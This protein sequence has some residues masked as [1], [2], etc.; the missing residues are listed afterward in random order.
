[1]DTTM[2]VFMYW[3]L[4]TYIHTVHTYIQTNIGYIL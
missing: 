3:Y 1:M 2:Q 4:C